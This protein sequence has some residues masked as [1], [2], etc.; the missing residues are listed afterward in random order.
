VTFSQAARSG[1]L[2]A[3]LVRR[4]TDLLMVR[5]EPS[6]ERDANWVLPGG[7]VESGESVHDALVRELR[8]E[9]GLQVPRPARL[10][11][12][13]QYTVTHDPSW[14]GAWT[15]FTFEVDVPPQDLA[16]A[17]PDG[18]VLEAAW[19]PL[20]VALGRLA[21]LSF[22]PRREPLLHYLRDGS[23]GQAS[24][25]LWLWPDGTDQDPVVVPGAAEAVSA[26]DDPVSTST[27]DYRHPCAWP[28][29][30]RA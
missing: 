3:A 10:A 8:E 20:S 6:G 12:L 1:L 9:T 11:F 30:P 24:A 5:E 18:L 23:N 7:Q 17:D 14:A 26:G 29:H 13:C 21:R 2:V 19:V 27:P 4:G 22:R 25:Q 16:P 28:L 15:V